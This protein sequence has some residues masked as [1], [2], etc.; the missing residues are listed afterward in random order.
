MLA[1]ANLNLQLP[2]SRKLKHKWVGPFVVEKVVNPVALRLGRGDGCSLPASYKFH[3]VVHA[4]WLKPYQD[5]SDQFPHRAKT[6]TAAHPLW[7][8]RDVPGESVPVYAVEQLL[9]RRVNAGVTEFQVKW[10]GY[11]DEKYYTWESA[12][13]LLKGGSDVQRMVNEWEAAIAAPAALTDS[14]PRTKAKQQCRASPKKATSSSQPT[15]TQLQQ[16]SRQPLAS[17]KQDIPS[18]AD[19]SRRQS[20]ETYGL[21]PRKRRALPTDFVSR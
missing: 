6:Y 10:L 3:P 8:E 2:G 19:E 15:A 7:F 21:R 14:T 13:N 17:P 20:A 4:H 1:T 11:D 18:Q 16:P 5:G 9:A 12:E